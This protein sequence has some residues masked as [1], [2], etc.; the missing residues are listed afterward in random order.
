MCPGSWYSLPDEAAALAALQACRLSPES[1]EA[2]YAYCRLLQE[3]DSH[4][5]LVANSQLPVLLKEHVIDSLKLAPWVSAGEQESPALVDVGS[6]A[7]FP[8]LVLAIALPGLRVTL[9]ESIG[10]K[11]RFLEET[12]EKLALA[13]RVRV[14]CGRAETLGHER[15]LRACFNFATARAVGAL[16]VV[17]ELCLPFLTVGGLLLAQ[18]SRRQALVEQSAPADWAGKLGAELVETAHLEPDLLGRE[19]SVLL[20]EKKQATHNRYARTAAQIKHEPL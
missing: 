3:Y 19:F 11:C 5:N 7:G 14:V 1:E 4:T 12:T 6:G 8:G 17:A 10:K 15:S 13:A 9:V 18:R 20:L 16:P 2:L